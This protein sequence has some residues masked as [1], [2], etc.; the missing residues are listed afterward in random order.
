LLHLREWIWLE[1]C[2]HVVRILM[3]A[4][5]FLST[6]FM[7]RILSVDDNSNDSLVIFLLFT[8]STSHNPEHTATSD[9]GPT[10][11]RSAANLSC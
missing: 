10:G 11:I 6:R 7:R 1:W 3:P 5:C 2:G 9:Q 4:T 8:W